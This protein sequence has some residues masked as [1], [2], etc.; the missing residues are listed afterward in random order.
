MIRVV[1]VSFATLVASTIA[2]QAH[3]DDETETRQ[4]TRE[5]IEAWLDARAVPG[6]RDVGEVEAP[7]EAPPLPPRRHGV[8]VE[9]G[10][11]V[12]NHLGPLKNVSPA[13]PYFHLQLGYEPFKWLMV[14]GESDVSFSDTSYANPPPEPRSYA[15][16]GFGFGARLTLL[17]LDRL[18]V[19][20]QFSIGTARV[21]DDVLNVYG[22]KEADDFNPYFGGMLG[23]EWY[24]SN[25]H[26]ALFL[27]GGARTYPDG[28]A[29]QRSSGT[30]AAVIV[31]AGLRYAF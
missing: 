25:P 23:L 10:V 18:G 6:T 1:C 4:M 12:F 5:E 14:F 31:S 13:A 17:P 7:P 24:Q 29:R 22:Y 28:F 21:S 27:N 8:V 2:R 26:Y 16:Y 11:G 20:A 9:T 15:L 19:Y 3:A 30:T